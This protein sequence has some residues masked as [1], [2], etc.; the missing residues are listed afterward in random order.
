[1]NDVLELYVPK[2]EDGWFYVKMMTDPATMAYNAPWFPP[3]GCIPNPEEEWEDLQKGWIGCEPKRFYAFLRRRSDGA[4]VGDVNYHFNPSRNWWDMG[5]VICA[6][7]RGKGYGKQGL[8]LLTDKALRVDGVG[9]LHNDFE[10][11][12]DA[13]YAIHRAVGFRDAGVWDGNIQ[14]ELSRDTYLHSTDG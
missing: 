3:D 13:A 8:R 1:M 6:H 10:T 9:L 14:L 12:R 7:E 11:A 5:I 2:P 4:F